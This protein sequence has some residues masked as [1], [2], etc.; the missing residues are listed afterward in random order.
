MD[1]LKNRTIQQYIAVGFLG[2]LF[3]LISG[4]WLSFNKLNLPLAWWAV[5]YVHERT[6]PTVYGLYLAPI[7]LGVMGGL[8][9][10]QVNLSTT[11]ARG[12]RE[13]EAI[14]DS[15]SD[16]IMITDPQ[17][18]IL[19][20][21]H[22]VVDR[23]NT[24]FPNVIGKPLSQ[25]LGLNESEDLRNIQNTEKEFYWLRRLYEVK[26]FPIGLKEEV[27][28]I[29]FILY[30]VT[31][32][33]QTEAKL[34]QSE[35]L[36]RGLFD[37]S[38]DAYVLIDPHAPNNTWPILDCNAATCSMNGYE[39]EELIGQSIDILNTSPGTGAE[40]AAYLKRLREAGH[41]KLEADHRHKSGVIF[42][43]EV[44][45]ALI[46]VGGRELVVGIDRD[47]TERRGIDAELTRQ[48]QFFESLVHNS[49]TAVVVLDNDEK[50]ISC[51]PAFE[52]L[53]G[54]QSAEIMG[55]MLDEL[56]TTDETRAEARRYTQ[57]VLSGTVH[58]LGHRRRKDHS[59]V[60]VEIFGVPVFVA[61]EKIGTLAIYHDISELVRARRQA[62]ESSRTKSE[63]LANMSHEIR[64]P[65]NGVI[66]M[67]ELAL[68]TPLT[69][70]QRDYLQTSL[71]SA[72]ALLTL[73]N[74]ILDFSKIE[75][76]RLELEKIN[77][78]L[79]NAVEDV[80]YTLAK[81]AQDKGLEMACLIDP[82]LAP[83]LRGDPGRLRQILVNLVGN[84]I[85]FTHQGEIVI[86]AEPREETATHVLI[87]FAVQDTGIGIPYERQAAVFDRFTQ[88][89]GSTTRK[90]GG[91]GLGLTISKQLV[92]AMG[93][94]LASRVR[95]VSGVRSGLI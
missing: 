70:E 50:I 49:P 45:T 63:F 29:L 55:I 33:R 89:D 39:R 85:K 73:L 43:V 23:L 38:P 21:N 24:T 31:E 15:L 12:K 8:L 34:E 86:H 72:E 13:W 60:D 76:G 80:A 35:A 46:T 44:S 20:C 51:N 94:R 83:E 57:Q 78:S 64:T 74:D 56:I 25:V 91:T 5:Y 47:I 62:E 22:A 19:R 11:I 30:D 92:D 48:K 95:Q 58:A 26:M 32:R 68:D 18:H 82:D 42:P 52:G 40:R 9:G 84:A 61:G 41:L 7:I 1:W 71:Q 6:E 3:L 54:Y 77:F 87:H 59:L 79:R 27:S 2:G 37:L 65:M 75:A 28:Q 93:G 14:F 67:L 17:G 66:G 81:R 36:F 10:L 53:F 4:F 90:Y 16:L 69:S 88:A